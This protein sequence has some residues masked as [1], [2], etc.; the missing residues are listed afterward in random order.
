MEDDHPSPP[1]TSRR[2][3]VSGVEIDDF[4]P[5]KPRIGRRESEPHSEEVTYIRDVLS[6]SYPLGRATWDLHHYF[7]VDGEEIDLELDVSFFKEWTFPGKLSSYRASEHG[8]RVPDLAVNILSKGTWRADVGEHVDLCRLIK[9]P[10]YAIF[11]PY[12]VAS[13]TYKPP[14]LRVYLMDEHGRYQFNELRE[15][16]VKA[17]G[18]VNWAATIDCGSHL[19]FKLGLMEIQGEKHEKGWPLYRLVF[20]DPAAR[21]TLI[22]KADRDEIRASVE[23]ARAEREKARADR[24]EREIDRLRKRD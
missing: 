17:G 2:T 19:P 5:S 13:R 16:T 11:S 8:N 1:E 14:F 24:A 21:K 20:L 6:F 22:R 4:D 10:A 15:I 3:Q 23:N 12:H 9:I 18:E 7:Q